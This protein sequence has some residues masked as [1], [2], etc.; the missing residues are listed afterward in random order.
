MLP[1]LQCTWLFLAM[2]ASPHD[3][4]LLRTLP[5]GYAGGHDDAVWRC[6]LAV[7]GDADPEVA[8]GCRLALPEAWD[9][10]APH[11]PR[12]QHAGL[13]GLMCCSFL[14]ARRSDAAAPAHPRSCLGRRVRVR[15]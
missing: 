4:H 15:C 5:S 2:C 12:P 6:L 3:E 11:A 13:L 14:R 10:S 7:L 8:D 1:D 9:G